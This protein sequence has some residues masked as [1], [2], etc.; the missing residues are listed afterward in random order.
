MPQSLSKI[1]VHIVFST[2]F[3]ENLIKEE[4]R[5]ELQKY[6]IG[7]LNDLKSYT[8]EIYINPDHLHILCTLPRTITIAQI[9]S[10][11]KAPSSKWMKT[12]GIVG[13]SWQDGYGAFSVSASNVDAVKKYI[14]NQPEHH[15]KE[16]FKEELVLFFKKYNIEYDERYVWD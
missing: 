15:K 6:I 5:Q 3:R 8:E 9:V 14:L 12:K 7:C 4:I 1:Y 13:F 2:K 16:N 10:K 11:I